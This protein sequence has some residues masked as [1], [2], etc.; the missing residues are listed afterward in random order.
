MKN[1]FTVS[2]DRRIILIWISRKVGVR[3]W[4]RFIWLR[5]E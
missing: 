4:N 5:V 1:A 2:G 3:V